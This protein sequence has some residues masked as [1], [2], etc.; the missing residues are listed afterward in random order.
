MK[1]VYPK[2]PMPG[3]EISAD[4]GRK[5]AQ[6][7]R[8]SRVLAGK[9]IRVDESMDGFMVSLQRTFPAHIVAGE[10][11]PGVWRVQFEGSEDAFTAKFSDCVFKRDS[12]T[13]IGTTTGEE[14][15]IVTFAM[16]VVAEGSELFL[17]FAYNSEDGAVDII[18]GDALKEVS[19]D[20]LPTDNI[21]IIRTPLY[22]VVFSGGWRVVMSYIALP[23]VGSYN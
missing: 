1:G 9:G 22:K 8:A 7:V 12:F 19:E 17:G 23:S 16:P 11:M 3:A 13:L 5:V 14:P 20:E 6:G 15:G 10:V 2:D 21:E 4:W 18:S